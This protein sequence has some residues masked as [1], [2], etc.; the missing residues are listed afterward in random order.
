MFHFLYFE[1]V[2]TFANQTS[3]FWSKARG[4]DGRGRLMICLRGCRG[5]F[6]SSYEEMKKTQEGRGGAK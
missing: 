1:S 4:V 5:T 3:T 6:W 2:L